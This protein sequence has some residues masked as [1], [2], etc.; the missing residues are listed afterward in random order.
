MTPTKVRRSTLGDQGG[1]VLLI[2]L[3]L[4]FVMTL[5]GIALFDLALVENHL[6]LASEGDAR[7]FNTAEAGLYRAQLNLTNGIGTTFDA[8]FTGGVTTTLYNGQSFS[9]GGAGTNYTVTAAPVAGSSPNLVTLDSTGCAW[10]TSPCASGKPQRTV[11][12]QLSRAWTMNAIIGL[13][14]V[15]ISANPGVIDSFDSSQGP[16]Q[17]AT[18]GSRV[19]VESNGTATLASGTLSGNL[20]STGSN[21]VVGTNGSVSGNAT[22]ATTVS[23]QGTVSGT[24]TQMQPAPPIVAPAIPACGPPYSSGSGMSGSYSY[25][26][27]TGD[28]KSTGTGTLA[29]A[30]GT[31]CFHNLTLNGG[32]TLQVNGAVVIKVTGVVDA[33]GGGFYNSTNIPANLQLLSSYTGS[34]GVTVKGGSGAYMTVYAPT[35]DVILM[36]TSDL[37]GAL[38]GKTLSVG[39]TASIHYDTAL[40][41]ASLVAGQSKFTMTS[42]KECR[43]PSCT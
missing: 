41:H 16:Y 7:A 32:A 35:T 40:D 9:Q 26:S 15:A 20:V 43:N 24:T 33:G 25:N 30:N 12:A 6:V 1:S 34:N 38:I 31:Y 29:L 3:V 4:V 5:L 2:S 23:V 42:W 28:L 8:V 37:Y 13:S 14:S 19:T 11:Q 39:G 10:A 36:G 22:A 18:A 21:V 27:A 17:A